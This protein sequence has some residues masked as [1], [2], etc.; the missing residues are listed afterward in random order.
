VY[1]KVS[2]QDFDQEMKAD[3]H[4]NKRRKIKQIADNIYQINTERT[5]S[6]LMSILAPFDKQSCTNAKSPFLA[7][8]TSSAV[9]FILVVKSYN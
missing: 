7:A 4:L 5:S 8:G 1:E 3:A 9:A 6:A 2:C